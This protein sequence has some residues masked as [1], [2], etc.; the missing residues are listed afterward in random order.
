MHPS[1]SLQNYVFSGVSTIRN[2][3]L[4]VKIYGLTTDLQLFSKG[5][6][7]TRIPNY[8][9]GKILLWQLWPYNSALY[10]LNGLNL[11]SNES[12]SYHISTKLKPNDQPLVVSLYML[13]ANI[14]F[15]IVDT[16]RVKKTLFCR[17][18]CV[19]VGWGVCGVGVG[20]GGW[21]WWWG[22]VVGVGVG[23]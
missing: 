21:W 23:G 18:V 3:M 5:A 7:K 1:T 13:T 20:V 11:V 2:K 4:T 16:L 8:R 6:L 19:W 14:I 12:Y 10:V 17:D 9:T 15:L 22:G